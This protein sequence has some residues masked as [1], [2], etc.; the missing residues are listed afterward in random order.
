MNF[1]T[2]VDI[3]MPD[4]LFGFENYR[5]FQLKESEYQPFLL[6]SSK[7]EKPL[8]FYLIDPFVFRPDYEI[9]VAD[10]SLKVIGITSPSDV[11]VMCVVTI[12]SD[13]TK[14]TAD[15]QGPIIINKK[16]VMQSRLYLEILAGLRSTI[17]LKNL[18]KMERKHAD[19][20]KKNQRENLHRGECNPYNN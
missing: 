20:I 18:V 3:T 16:M 4:G 6:L 11:I 7:D 9:D 2:P 19:S 12:P 17:F 5:N 13:G 8:S 15:L 1:K 14:I 10:E